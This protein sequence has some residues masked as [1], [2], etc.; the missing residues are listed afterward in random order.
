MTMT[1]LIIFVGGIGGGEAEEMVAAAHRAI[2]LDTLQRATATGNFDEIIVITDMD[3]LAQQISPPV[4]VELDQSPF[5]FGKRLRDVI[6]RY[7]IDKPFYVGGGSIPLL[8]SQELGAIA[9]QLSSATN[10]VITN[11]LFSADLV[12]FTPGE[13]I[14]EIDP[15]A[16]DNPLA[17]L[18]CRQANLSAVCLPQSAATLFD[19][20]TPADLLILKVHP[21]VGPKTRQLV[22]NIELDLTRLR[23]AMRFLT[24]TEAEILVAGRVGSYLWAHLE[25]DTACQVRTLSEER[26]LRADGREE[27]G[28]VR[29]ILGFYLE[30]VGVTRFFETL[31]ELGDAAFIDTRVIFN[32][33]GLNLSRSDRFHSD[34]G[35]PERIVNPFVRQFT[36][37]AIEAPIPVVLGGHSLVAGGL[38]ALIDAALLERD[39]KL[40]QGC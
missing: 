6:E 16:T 1:T 2:T 5:H 34:L 37:G 25:R 31:G 19:V 35:Q 3:E 10:T 38:L 13:A 11:N 20:D 7:K 32:H 29:S 8:S 23:Q 40:R 21:S 18:L 27:R 36:E 17:Q 28:E 15:P 14:E 22:N 9:K 12:A 30:Q 26:G 33:L 39:E 24:N 4:R